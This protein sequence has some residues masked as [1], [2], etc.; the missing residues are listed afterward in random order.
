MDEEEG[1]LYGGGVLE[2]WSSSV[3]SEGWTEGRDGPVS[4]GSW[5]AKLGS[6]MPFRGTDC[7]AGDIAKEGQG[8]VFYF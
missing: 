8:C 2:Q 5:T 3:R 7:L 1:P 4:E 6:G